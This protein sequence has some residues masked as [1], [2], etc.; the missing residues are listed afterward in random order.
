V[1]APIVFLLE[2]LM[3]RQCEIDWVNNILLKFQEDMIP[4]GNKDQTNKFLYPFLIAESV[5]KRAI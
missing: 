5:R 2:S 4:V 1:I 3:K